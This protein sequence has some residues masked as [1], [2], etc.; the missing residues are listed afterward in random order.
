MVTTETL[1]TAFIPVPVNETELLAPGAGFAAS[2]FWNF[3][4]CQLLTSLSRFRS[5]KM[6]LGVKVSFL[7]EE[8]PEKNK[9]SLRLLCCNCQA[10]KSVRS[11]R[12]QGV[13]AHVGCEDGDCPLPW[14]Q[15]V[16]SSQVPA[17]L[18]QFLPLRSSSLS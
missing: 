13:A 10:S 4:N 7:M 14:T 17:T 9:A 5:H 12:L 2:L 18:P 1:R 11:V 15:L 8:K 6:G 16:E 3:V